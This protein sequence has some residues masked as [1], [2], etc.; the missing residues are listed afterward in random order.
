MVGSR[1][2]GIVPR[3]SAV[4]HLRR[5]AGPV[6]VVVMNPVADGG[7]NGVPQMHAVFENLDSALVVA[8][9]LVK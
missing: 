8:S 7:P 9:R 6:I 2:T 5:W 4:N 1:S 3:T